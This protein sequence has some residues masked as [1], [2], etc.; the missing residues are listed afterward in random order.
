MSY[1]RFPKLAKVSGGKNI[2]MLSS[3]TG[4]KFEKDGDDLVIPSNDPK[5]IQGP[6]PVLK[7]EPR[8]I[9]INK[10]DEI[11]STFTSH[12]ISKELEETMKGRLPKQVEISGDF[13]LLSKIQMQKH[14]FFFRYHQ[15]LKRCAH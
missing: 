13:G 6:Q 1:I 12:Y 14:R 9:S 15:Q 10:P 7:T 8:P 11:A 2:D 4:Y 3:G 5:L